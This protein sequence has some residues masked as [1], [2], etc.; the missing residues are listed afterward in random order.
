MR[1][2]GHPEAEAIDRFATG[3]EASRRESREI[4]LHLLRGCPDCQ[5]LVREALRPEVEPENV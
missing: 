1:S 4:V 5:K 2:A 3:R